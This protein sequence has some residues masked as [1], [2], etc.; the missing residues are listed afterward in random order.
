MSNKITDAR[1]QELTRLQNLKN[2]LQEKIRQEQEAMQAILDSMSAEAQ[3]LASSSSRAT[4]E[5]R[6]KESSSLSHEDVI[7]AHGIAIAR[8]EE[9]FSK[10]V[11]ELEGLEE[12]MKAP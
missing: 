11:E 1:I 8:L 12:L 7:D 5:A 2:E 9:Q 3:E 4:K 6:R 10:V